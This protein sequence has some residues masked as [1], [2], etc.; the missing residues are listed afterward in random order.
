MFE[1]IARAERW[2]HANGP[3]IRGELEDVA[4]AIARIAA[5]VERIAAV[6]E[7]RLGNHDIPEVIDGEAHELPTHDELP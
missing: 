5:A 2:V 7:R 1:T 3:R 6:V 4:I